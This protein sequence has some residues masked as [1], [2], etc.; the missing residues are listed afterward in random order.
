LLAALNDRLVVA[1]GASVAVGRVATVDVQQ[2]LTGLLEP[3]LA[4]WVSLV[5]SQGPHP[6]LHLPKL[7]SQLISRFDVMRLTPR[8][9][10]LLSRGP[11]ICCQL[12]LELSETG[13]QFNSEVRVMSAM[14][15][16]NFDKALDIL[17]TDFH[18]S[19][20]YPR[21]PPSSRLFH[22]FRQLGRRC[23]TFA[24]FDKAKATF[25][26]VGDYEAMYDLFIAHMNPSALRRLAATLEES[27]AQPELE[28]ECMQVL[29]VRSSLWNQGG[30]LSAIAQEALAPKP[31]DWA[32]GNWTV[33]VA[34]DPSEAKPAAGTAAAADAAAAAAG[35]AG[36][37]N[38]GAAGAVTA[39]AAAAGGLK[40][41]AEISHSWTFGNEVTAY[42]KTEGGA[43][44]VIMADSVGVYLGVARGK[45]VVT[46][47]LE[48]KKEEAKKEEKKKK[49][50]ATEA[51]IM[52]AAVASFLPGAEA[53][54]AAAGGAVP[55]G[56]ETAEE[57]QQ[58]AAAE[59]KT[60]MY[61]AGE[62]F[63]SDSD[64][65]TM[66]TTSR[67]SKFS[68]KIKDK[69]ARAGVVDVGRLK[70]A[71]KT[72]TLGAPAKPPSS[73]A[74]EEFGWQQ[75][76]S[77][78]SGLAI[79]PFGDAAAAAAAQPAA[80]GMPPAAGGPVWANPP[81]LAALGMGAGGGVP[82]QAVA[83]GYAKPMLPPGQQGAAGP[84]AGAAAAAAAAAAAGAGGAVGAEVVGESKELF[85]DDIPFSAEPSFQAA[86]PAQAEAAAAGTGKQRPMLPPPSAGPLQMQPAATAAAAAEPAA[87]EEFGG[88]L[89]GTAEGQGRGEPG[90][91]LKVPLPKSAAGAEGA[92]AN[93]LPPEISALSDAQAAGEKG[94]SK[95]QEAA[96]AAMPTKILPGYVPRGASAAVCVKV[97]LVHVDDNRLADALA[98]VDEAFL[99][100]AKDR[101]LGKNVQAQARIAAHYK[102]GATILQEIVRLQKA[103]GQGALGAKE[104]MARLARHL[105]SLPLQPKHRISCARTAIRRNMEVH[106][107]AY[108][109]RLLHAL[110]A[111][112]PPNKQAE[113]RALANICMARGLT[114]RTINRSEDPSRFCAASLALLPTIGH[115]VCDTCNACFAALA[116]P[117]CPI[118]GMGTVRRFDKAGAGAAGAGGGGAAGRAAAAGGQAGRGKGGVTAFASPF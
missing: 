85:G 78:S 76:E 60:S 8:L 38:V 31:A 21:C 109:N 75:F 49:K 3:L 71:S 100:M 29:K 35:A 30:V 42:M 90:Q 17:T 16:R 12:A 37:A 18:H 50:K 95:E 108:S 106:N 22:R 94:P 26:V 57:A 117:G 13:P 87:Q 28:R 15:A 84:E 77:D 63:D 61:G 83:L 32:G 89:A 114:D 69:D 70:A 46:E 97:A 25:E 52:A 1:T 9:V 104:E 105:A 14:R 34:P 19:T 118:C 111:K 2:R 65:D 51:E 113:L 44:P 72:L 82:A 96:R 39:V 81:G 91:Q 64:D 66:S 102:I 58:R 107:F 36:G 88:L 48:M 80:N 5:H 74:T 112:A 27:E 101:S 115:D 4:G 54:S 56:E 59:F 23:I 53:A 45:G 33:L 40:P 86:Q 24:Q 116:T 47:I 68:I 20:S 10:E 110:L 7:I 99:A 103:E 98:C 11:T 41:Q 79:V 62:A 55:R 43:I 92:G 73:A 93:A 67:R 6:M